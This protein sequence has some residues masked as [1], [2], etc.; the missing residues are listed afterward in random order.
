MGVAISIFRDATNNGAD[1]IIH[2]LDA[3][4]AWRAAARLTKDE[5]EFEAHT[6]TLRLLEIAVARSRSLEAQFSQLM[7]VA[8]RHVK[9]VACDAAALALEQGDPELAVSL[10]EQGRTVI[11]RQ[12]G[13]FRT[14][15]EDVREVAPALAERFTSLSQ[16][17][18]K[19]VLSGGRD[20]PTDKPSKVFEDD[21]S[22]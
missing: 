5:S 2:R 22:R 6:T 12:L 20:V 21:V 11:F 17:L 4:Q 14:V 18:D 3:A 16:L 10:L 15:L 19:F 9:N 13:H 1:S 8:I 7:R